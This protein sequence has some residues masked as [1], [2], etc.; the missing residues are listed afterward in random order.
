MTGRRTRS[1]RKEFSERGFHF[2]P[3]VIVFFLALLGASRASQPSEREN[4]IGETPHSISSLQSEGEGSSGSLR[5][6]LQTHGNALLQLRESDSQLAEMDADDD[7]S[8]G[9]AV[10]KIISIAHPGVCEKMIR[11]DRFVG[12]VTDPVKKIS[13]CF[14]KIKSG[15][16]PPRREIIK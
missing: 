8:E 5:V 16:D 14:Q 10:S 6:R 3:V 13:V 7:G 1:N 11:Q 15:V 4:Q 9:A 2:T 12:L